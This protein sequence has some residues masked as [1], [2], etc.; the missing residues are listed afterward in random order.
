MGKRVMVIE[1]N[2]ILRKFLD[3][4]IQRDGHD[5]KV[6]ANYELALNAFALPTFQAHPPDLVFIAVYP[7]QPKSYSV[8]AHLRSQFPYAR[9][10]V[11]AMVAQEDTT[12]QEVKSLVQVTQTILLLKPYQVQDV[13][14]LVTTP[15]QSV[16]VKQKQ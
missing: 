7:I 3:L 6:F 2:G 16:S 13:L 5:V 8:I 10:T 4:C 11:V 15:G 12:Y 9:T 1:P 14:A